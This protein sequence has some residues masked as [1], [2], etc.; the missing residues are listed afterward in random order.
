MTET[1]KQ[2]KN[3]SEY[4]ADYRR[5][6]AERIREYSNDY[7]LRNQELI[8]MRRRERYHEMKPRKD[9]AR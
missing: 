3:R 5:K 4:F 9:L 2:S 8:R 6:N 7:Y 1:E